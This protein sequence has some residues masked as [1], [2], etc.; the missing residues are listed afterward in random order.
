MRFLTS[1]ALASI[2]G[3]GI[4]GAQPAPRKEPVHFSGTETA[5][6]VEARPPG[7]RLGLNRPREFALSPLSESEKARLATPGPR[8]RTG[9][10]REL[11]AGLLQGGAWLT[12]PDGTPLWRA[13]LRSPGAAGIR[14]EFREFSVGAGK[15]WLYDG[16]RFV[17]PYSGRGPYD[18]GHF[19]S[20]TVASGSV[21][22]EYQPETAAGGEPP[23]RIGSISHQVRAVTPLNTDASTAD[24]ADFCNL[25][26]NCFASWQPAM[27][28]VG[29]LDFED[30]GDEYVCTGSLVATRD[31][32]MI[33]Y[34]LTAGHC[35]N[36]EAAARTVEVYWKYQT[37]S[38]GGG[39]PD[40]STSETSPLGTHLLDWGTIEQGDYSL[41]LLK[42]VPSDVTFSGW[43]PS[44]PPITSSVVGI[45]HPADSWKRISFGTRVDDATE[46]VEN[47]SGGINVAPADMYFQ[48][49]Y[50]Q[51]RVQPGS[52]GSPLFTSP[53]IIVGTLTFGPVD[54]VYTA[55]EIDP[56]VAGYGRF[57]NAYQNLQA[58]FENTPA[59]NVTPTPA[60]LSFSVVN[61]AAPA[62]QTVTLTSQ[63]TGS[64]SFRVRPDALWLGVSATSGQ[65]SL[66]S[67]LTLKVT[68][69]PSQLPQPGQYSS[70]LTVL[71][72]SA[73]P[74][75][76]NVTV[77][78][79][80]SQSNVNALVAPATVTA[81]NGVW[82]F[83]IQL[84]ETAGVA[85]RVTALKIGG[86]DYSANIA[87][88]F[89]TNRIA[90]MGAVQASLKASGLP[91]GPQYFEFWGA[92]EASGQTWYRIAS[93]TFK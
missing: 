10:H 40:R 24:G 79:Q 4:A 70:T 91:A 5:P 53:G 55:C 80:T 11:P 90:A 39:T 78:V 85:T 93:A 61:G 3:V 29:Q 43:D 6:R 36:S 13:A 20:E 49:Q 64:V 50:V 73:A 62:A 41:L 15:V 57:S 16:A 54:P 81:V 34:L 84:A 22:L 77:T 92:D 48:V 25:D 31:N 28:M 1:A 37:A 27:K 51:G 82:G 2:L 12:A 76:V 21:I 38:C 68:V 18:D 46:A 88:W 56:F 26:P 32:S 30:G 89:G 8:L 72:G 23:F 71:A 14:V 52:S 33:P 66:G 65:V 17:G 69:D 42:S 63:T 59:S 47:D 45:H 19:W 44:D 7:I 67:P 58:Y 9:I 87:A 75:F 74:Q 83:Q 60:A 86:T 35:I